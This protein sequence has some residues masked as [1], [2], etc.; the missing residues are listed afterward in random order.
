M[1]WNRVLS[2]L[3]ALIYLLLA[4][5]A[6]GLETGLKLL[7]FLILPLACIWFSDAMGRYT[8]R[9]PISAGGIN[10]QSPGCLVCIVGWLLLLL[11]LIIGIVYLIF[12]V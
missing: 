8:G 6:G 11:P 4:L 7:A 5:F 1:D 3:L 10:Q 9:F 2:G 12:G